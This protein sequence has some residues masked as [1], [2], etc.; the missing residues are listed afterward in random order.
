MPHYLL[1]LSPIAWKGKFVDL[2][3]RM[4]GFEDAWLLPAT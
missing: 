3:S 4:F 1:S 2:W